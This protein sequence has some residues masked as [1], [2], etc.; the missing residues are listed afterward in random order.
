MGLVDETALM[1]DG[2]C[3]VPLWRGQEHGMAFPTA[4]VV[5]SGSRLGAGASV[6]G[7]EAALAE[8]TLKERFGA[9][10]G[11]AGAEGQP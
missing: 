9:D 7:L 1:A 3:G 4:L 6:R 8:A 2:S 10:R 5:S 11:S